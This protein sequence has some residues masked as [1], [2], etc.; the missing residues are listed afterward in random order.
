MKFNYKV[1][2]NG[3][4]YFCQTAEAAARLCEQETA[5]PGHYKIEVTRL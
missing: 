3:K 4:R 1:V 5:K 2:I